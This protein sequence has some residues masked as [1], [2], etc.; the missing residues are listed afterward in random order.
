VLNGLTFS[1][2]I[3]EDEKHAVRVP[4]DDLLELKNDEGMFTE[5]LF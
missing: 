4:F 1:Q 2:P 3:S 5:L